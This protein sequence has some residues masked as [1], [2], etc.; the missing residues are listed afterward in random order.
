MKQYYVAGADGQKQGP[1][2]E[3]Y[4]RSQYLAGVY[5]P[6]TLVWCEGMPQ[7][8]PIAS[9][10]T[11][12]L[13]FGTAGSAYVGPSEAQ[14]NNPFRAMAY[15]FRNIFN[16]NGRARRKEFW[17]AVLGISLTTFA[18]VTIL[19]LASAMFVVPA[20]EEI[21]VSAAQ[22][23][24]AGMAQEEAV[25]AAVQ[26][27][28]QDRE[29]LGAAWGITIALY[30]FVILTFFLVNLSMT[31]RRLHDL[32]YSGWLQLINIVPYLGAIVLFVL[33]CLDSQPGTNQY[34]PNPKS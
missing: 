12:E 21:A 2:D 31:C 26:A 8:L 29:P 28:M 16:Y 24:E 19:L 10:L 13:V 17:M 32:G 25:E 7:W 20:M 27:S 18:I 3:A 11:D 5:K 23:A 14:L 33:C 34:G 15:V 1:F 9:V 6:N 30:M 4:V 22:S